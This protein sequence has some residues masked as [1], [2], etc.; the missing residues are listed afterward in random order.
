MSWCDLSLTF[1][2]L[3]T[4]TFKIL[5]GLYLGNCTCRKLCMERILVGG[6]RFAASWCDLDLAFDLAIV[7]LIFKIGV[8]FNL[9]QC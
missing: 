4:V 5:S 1:D 6:C 2:L 9:I 7:T 3:M 8:I